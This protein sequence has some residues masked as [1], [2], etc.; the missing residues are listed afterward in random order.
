MKPYRSMGNRY[1]RKINFTTWPLQ[2]RQSS[3]YPVNRGLDGPQKHSWPVL[4]SRVVQAV[5]RLCTDYAKIEQHASVSF[6]GARVPISL[7]PPDDRDV[8]ITLGNTTRGRT[9]LDEWSAQCRHL[10]LPI[11]N[12]H[13]RQ[14]STPPPGFEPESKRSQTHN[15]DRAVTAIS[16]MLP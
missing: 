6:H 12:I 10:C 1:R 8:T 2:P 3:R 16:T 14:T 9:P 7:G 5:T 13:K 4:D 11:Y 15:L